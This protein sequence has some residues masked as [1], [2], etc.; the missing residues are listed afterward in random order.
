M[1][2]KIIKSLDKPERALFWF[3]VHHDCGFCP[4][5]CRESGF[6]FPTGRV[7]RSSRRSL[8]MQCKTCGMQWTVTVHRVAQVTARKA[9]Q[10]GRLQ[11]DWRAAL[12]AE[13]A[14]SVDDQRGRRRKV[15]EP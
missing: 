3:S 4:S 9:E 12:W 10:E 6:G 11:P 13:W 8:T 5:G 7:Y 1:I 15:K 2:A 14:S